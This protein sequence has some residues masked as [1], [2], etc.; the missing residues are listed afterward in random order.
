MADDYSQG[1]DAGKQGNMYTGG[2]SIE[3]AGWAAG[4]EARHQSERSR[5]GGGGGGGAINFKGRVFTS[6]II[7]GMLGMVMG[8]MWYGTVGG[9]VGFGVGMAIGCAIW[10][11][12]ALA[13]QIFKRV[14]LLFP[15]LLGAFVG[16]V[17]GVGIAVRT[18][19]ARDPFMIRYAVLGAVLC[20]GLSLLWRLVTRSRR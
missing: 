18:G 19:Q 16:A 9:F 17:Y 1:Y 20:V 2:G 11:L 10:L 14:T 13:G 8:L 4:N 7:V 12:G 15:L 3:Y 5:G 6:G